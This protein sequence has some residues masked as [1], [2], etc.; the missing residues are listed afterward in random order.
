[1][2]HSNQPVQ[3]SALIRTLRRYWIVLVALTIVGYALIAGAPAWAAP[4]SAPSQQTV[5]TKSHMY[6]PWILLDSH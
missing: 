1:M 4:V 5:P 3:L 2:A 6:L